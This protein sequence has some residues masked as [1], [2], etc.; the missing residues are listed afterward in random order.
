MIILTSSSK[1]FRL[2]GDEV[3]E[4]LRDRFAL[5]A[6]GCCEV[7]N[8]EVVESVVFAIR[9]SLKSQV[10]QNLLS[11]FSNT[12]AKSFKLCTHSTLTVAENHLASKLRVALK[13]P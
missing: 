3:F 11:P 9:N 4:V 2:D 8:A 5:C 13:S 1:Q 12:R 7:P 6:K 10:K